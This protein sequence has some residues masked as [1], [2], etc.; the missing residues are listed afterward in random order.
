MTPDEFDQIVHPLPKGAPPP[1]PVSEV[2]RV[3]ALWRKIFPA[4]R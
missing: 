3:V 2:N 1:I 4:P